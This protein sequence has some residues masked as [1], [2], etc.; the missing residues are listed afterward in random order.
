VFYQHDESYLG[1]QGNKCWRGLWI[2]NNVKDGEFDEKPV[3]MRHLLEKY[4]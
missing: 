1:P 3:S 2:L 4:S